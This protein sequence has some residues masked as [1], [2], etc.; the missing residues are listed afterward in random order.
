MI[1]LTIVRVWFKRHTCIS[2][3]VINLYLGPVRVGL[4]G[5]DILKLDDVVVSVQSPPVDVSEEVLFSSDEI[6]VN[7]PLV[8]VTTMVSV[9]QLAGCDDSN[10]VGGDSGQGLLS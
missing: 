7:S 8:P 9:T 10:V 5:T 2:P 1:L 4:V 3:S 6:S